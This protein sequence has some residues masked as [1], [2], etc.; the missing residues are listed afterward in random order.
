MY[1]KVTLLEI[2][3]EI[4]FVTVHHVTG[5]CNFQNKVI[6]NVLFELLKDQDQRV[7][8]ASSMAIVK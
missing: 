6:F 5:D 7:R 2:L 4:P 8:T 1:F 3:Q